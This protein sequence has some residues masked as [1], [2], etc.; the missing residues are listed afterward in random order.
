[1]RRGVR[2]SAIVVGLPLSTVARNKNDSGQ[3][4]ATTTAPTTTVPRLTALAE[5]PQVRSADSRNCD[6]A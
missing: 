2:Y 4:F 3:P 6:D 5:L 1:M